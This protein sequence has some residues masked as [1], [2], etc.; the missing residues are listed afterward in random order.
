[1]DPRITQHAELMIDYSLKLKAGEKI[2]ISG[3]IE[4]LPMLK[5]C[6]RLSIER[7]AFPEINISS[8]DFQEIMLKNGT[9]EQ[10]KYTSPSAFRRIETADTVLSVLG[11]SNTRMM[12]NI[13]GEKLKLS[14]QGRTEIRKLLFEREKKGELRWTLTLFPTVANAQEAGMSLAEFQDFVYD[15]C[16]LNL[17][18]PVDYWLSVDREQ[19]RIC[20]IL[21]TKKHFRFLSDDTDLTLSAEGRK[22]ENCSGTVNFPDGEVFTGPVEDSVEGTIRFSFPGIYRGKEIEDIKLTF[23][24]GKVVKA[25]AEK[26]ED[27][28]HQL[29]DTD[30]GAKYVGEIAIG[31]NNNIKKFIK[32]ILFDEKIGG[33]IHLAVGKSFFET[34]GKNDSAIHWDMIC[35]MSCNGKIFADGKLIYQNGNFQF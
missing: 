6:Y 12:N 33:T 31:T 23:K 10:I 19:D 3:S 27:L 7:G 21:E 18:N 9:D 20:K 24:K 16:G 34:G 8:D 35:D 11:S 2:L 4:T 30:K 25:S 26:G 29:L 14:A 28:L 5:E 17:K 22:W 13:P 15:A 32:N 1:M